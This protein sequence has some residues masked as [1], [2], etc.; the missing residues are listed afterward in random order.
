MDTAP[1]TLRDVADL[2]FEA[3]T[4]IDFYWNFYVVVVIAV[5][6]WIVTVKKALT[7]PIKL[8]VTTAFLI[9]AATNLVGLYSAYSVAE[10]LRVDLLRVGA[11]SPLTDTRLLLEQH[12]YASHRA[13]AIGVHVVIGAAILLTVWYGRLIPPELKPGI[14]E[15]GV[16]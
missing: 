3:R 8:L 2:L 4:R 16:G 7:L 1:L 15:K 11:A 5:I 10:A 6:G 9:A 14:D 13:V 12:S